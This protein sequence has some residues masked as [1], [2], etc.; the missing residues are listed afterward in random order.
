MRTAGT[1][2]HP[3]GPF[4]LPGTYTVT[5]AANGMTASRSLTVRLDPRLQVS[6]RDLREQLERTRT[7]IAVLERGVGALRDIE[8]VRSARG[9]DLPGALGDSLARLTGA[10]EPN[11]RSV[12]RSLSGLVDDLQAADAAPTQGVKAALEDCTRRVDGL[13]ARWRRLEATIAASGAH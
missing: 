3:A 1:P 10:D 13:V 8:R 6:E 7:A 5:L 2:L 11:L 9:A 4:V 12:T